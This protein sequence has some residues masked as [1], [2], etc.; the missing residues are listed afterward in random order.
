MEYS[1]LHECDMKVGARHSCVDM[2]NL[3]HAN[4]AEVDGVHY[5]KIDSTIEMDVDSNAAVEN[6]KFLFYFRMGNCT[7]GVFGLQ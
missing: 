2:Y 3:T 7:D 4:Y 5:I 1:T 6:G